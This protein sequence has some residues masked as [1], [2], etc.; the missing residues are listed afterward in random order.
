MPFNSSSAV[1]IN[2]HALSVIL[3]KQEQETVTDNKITELPTTEG[4]HY[5][6]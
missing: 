5:D 3:H 2:L 6:V 4:K 1:D